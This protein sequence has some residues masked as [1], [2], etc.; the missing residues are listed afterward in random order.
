M[1]HKI[2]P[3]FP[4]AIYQSNIQRAFTDIELSAIESYRSNLIDNI[5]NTQTFDHDVLSNDSLQDIKTFIIHNLIT[6]Y[7]QIINPRDKLQLYITQ[8][9]LNYTKSNQYHHKHKHPNSILS[10]VLYINT[11]PKVDRVSF[12]HDDYERIEIIP[13]QYNQFNSKAWTTSVDIGDI[14][15]F[16]SDLSHMVETK[17]GENERISLAFNT[18]VRGELG[19]ELGASKLIIR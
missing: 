1:M 18:F 11:N 14:L 16:P 3:I 19:E 15:I 8:S 7:Q 17:I 2:I 13:K 9:W 12:Y 5:G 4:K 10:G 6:Y